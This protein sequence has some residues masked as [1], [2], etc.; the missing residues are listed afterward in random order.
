MGFN[1]NNSQKSISSLRVFISC[2]LPDYVC[3]DISQSFKAVFNTADKFPD[4]G[5]LVEL[6]SGVD[7][8]IVT[9]TDTLDRDTICRLSPGIKAIATYSVGIDHID[10]EAARESGIAVFNTPD[11]LTDAVAEVAMLL[12]IGAA[13][14]ATESICLIRNGRWE[15]WTPEQ[16]NGIELRGKSLGILG[17]GRIGQAVAH[18]ATAFGMNILYTNSRRLPP[19][20]EGTAHFHQNPEKMLSLADVVMLSCPSTPETYH[21]L[22]ES[23]ISRMQPGS[24][25]VNIGRGSV[26]HDPSLIAALRSGHIRAAGLDVFENE[27]AFDRRYLELPN[28][29][30]LPHI[31]SSTVETRR[32]M[33]LLLIEGLRQFERGEMPSNRLV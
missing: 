2:T 14:R 27:P 5:K 12:I 1:K 31:G 7:A 11:V 28:V 8:I 6:L 21:F 20:L 9:A 29:F 15:G 18:R 16:L 32:R 25:V 33:G 26:V 10:L 23:R 4:Q 19:E 24:I 17:M 3:H 30:M 22:N 13:R